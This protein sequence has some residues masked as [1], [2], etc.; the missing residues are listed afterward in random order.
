MHIRTVQRI[1]GVLLM[2]FSVTMLP[3]IAVSLWYRDGE[4][5]HFLISLGLTFA[6][7]FVLWLPVRRRRTELRT[8]EGFMVV[9]LFWT[10]LSV[11][12]A[13]PFHLSPHLDWTDAIFEAV[14]GFTTTGATVMTGLD[15]LPPS[16]LYYRQQ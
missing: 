11:L 3:P 12:S 4:I 14:S 15:R 2:A 1:L 5:K 7:G 13:L 6:V 10:V 9:T 16:L 8:R